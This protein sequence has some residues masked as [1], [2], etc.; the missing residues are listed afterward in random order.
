MDRRH[1]VVL[2]PDQP[3]YACAQMRRH[4]GVPSGLYAPRLQALRDQSPMGSV[5]TPP[6]TPSSTRVGRT[7]VKKG[8]SVMCENT[9]PVLVAVLLAAICFANSCGGVLGSIGLTRC[10]HGK[11]ETLTLGAS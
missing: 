3:A 7:A 8:L 9:E 4:V 5:S 1:R 2:S 10:V 11:T 6:P